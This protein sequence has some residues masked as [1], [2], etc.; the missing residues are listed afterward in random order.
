M[1]PCL[2]CG[3]CCAYYRASFYWR[4][5][6]DVT[7]GGVPI[8]LTQDLTDFR[9]VMKGTNRKAPRC[10]A[11]VGTIG[12]RVYCAIY[13]RRATPCRAFA[14]SYSDGQPHE[15]CDR[16]RAAHGLPPLTMQDWQGPDKTLRPAA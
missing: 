5:A 8:E 12:Q 9:L 7:P 3:A 13:D 14:P 6:S 15:R 1:N 10:V 11:L 16:A 4:E 2:R